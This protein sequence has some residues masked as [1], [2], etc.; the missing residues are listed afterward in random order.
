MPA[1]SRTCSEA[2]YRS[3]LRSRR[4]DYTEAW[5]TAGGGGYLRVCP[6]HTT[7]TS[8]K[9][10]ASLPGSG[11]LTW[12]DAVR[13]C[14]LA[15]SWLPQP[16]WLVW[17]SAPAEQVAPCP[18]PGSSRTGGCSSP[19]PCRAHWRQPPRRSHAPESPC[20]LSARGV[21]RIPLLSD[22]FIYFRVFLLLTS[23]KLLCLQCR[24]IIIFTL[25]LPC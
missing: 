9:A 3:R 18:V 24:V 8:H 6:P 20:L 25:K 23:S 16:E 11:L 12:H 14:G 5:I 15:S 22:I 19:R 7:K 10:R 13:V 2:G 17:C 1:P 4:Q 21:W